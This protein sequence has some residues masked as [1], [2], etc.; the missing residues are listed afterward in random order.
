MTLSLNF[1]GI[2]NS[3]LILSLL[4]SSVA[5]CHGQ[6]LTPAKATTS[7]QTDAKPSDA[8]SDKATEDSKD[9]A[10]KDKKDK[11]EEEKLL[12]LSFRN[13]DMNKIGQFLSN[14]MKKP[15]VLADKV[16]SKKISII[17][18]QKKK[19][20]ELL[21]VLR[22]TL[23][24]NGV[25]IEELET[26][27]NLKPTEDMK[28]ANLPI[29]SAT[30]SLNDIEDQTLIV[31]K[32]FKVQYYDVQEIEKVIKPLLPDYVPIIVDPSTKSLIIS[33]MV[34]QL[35]RVEGVINTLDL[36]QVNKTE[37][38]IIKVENADAAWIV[39]VLK[40]LLNN[41]DAKALTSSNS[42][43]RSRNSYYGW[44]GRSNPTPQ[45][46]GNT[47]VVIPRSDGA[48]I[49]MPEIAKN[50]I[51]AV[52]P[53]ETMLQIIK[54]VD[55]L[56]APTDG[57]EAFQM[58][59]IKY[60]NVKTISEEI[61]LVISSMPDLSNSVNI[62]PSIPARKLFVTGSQKGHK[63]VEILLKELD[64][65]NAGNRQMQ[66]FKLEYA[67]SVVIAENIEK[68]FDNRE[69]ES[70]Y[71]NY[72]KSY[73]KSDSASTRIK[74]TS[75]KTQNAVI[76]QTDSVTMDKVTKKIQE[77]D[78]PIN[79]EDVK[80][81]IYTLKYA[82]PVKVEDI[83]VNLYSKKVKENSY[84]SWW[85][86]EPEE[87][88]TPAGRLFGEFSFQSLADTNQ[89]VVSAKNN[90]NFAII[91]EIIAELDQPQS[92]G[93]PKVVELKHANAE[94]LAEQLNAALSKSG[95]IASILRSSRGQLTSTGTSTASNSQNN[96]NNSKNNANSNSE[97]M[98]FW[99]EKGDDNEKERPASSMIGKL[100][101][102]PIVRRNALLIVAAPA[103]IDSICSMVE[104]LDVPGMQVI[105]HARIAEIQH[106]DVTTLGARIS[107]DPDAFKDSASADQSIRL[108]G[109]VGYEDVFGQLFTNNNGNKTSQGIFGANIN[110]NMLIQFLQRKYGLQILYEPKLYTADNQL[111]EFFDGQ[112]IAVQKNAQTTSD[113]G[114]TRTFD[115]KAIGTRL[116]V[117]PHIT[118]EG[119]VDLKVNL[120]LSRILPSQSFYGNPTFDR[121]ETNT[122]V[123][124]HSG[125]TV[126]LSGIIRTEDFIDERKLPLVSEIPLLGELFKSKDKSRKNRE[127]II[128]ITPIV[129]SNNHEETDDVMA[130]YKETL[131]AIERNLNGIPEPAP[132]PES[133][134]EFL[135]EH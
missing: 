83:L 96:N 112:D 102:V 116:K 47:P 58:Y 32:C 59:S 5:V 62:V 87:E 39:S 24:Q 35:L 109:N 37:K 49:L 134:P 12:A 29:V 55:R 25:F 65:E 57:E 119:E 85:N 63:I 76:V 9:K 27:I 120:E 75:D 26:H 2:L 123:V 31:R 43:S 18:N 90:K 54:W 113:G 104:E 79:P 14:E 94:E 128:F 114:T 111:A 98:R 69:L 7:A 126:M 45:M 84:R 86:D 80:P 118:K 99:W 36:P 93:M 13:A 20:K 121:R 68:L 92:V 64:V 48:V 50:W 74:V 6:G 10:K 108:G 52:A 107:S 21:P 73:R 71:G 125:Q 135:A 132:A 11:K 3:V 22:Q 105:I 66:T 117:R 133:E 23:Y 56:D 131:N 60:S 70:S 46:K 82:D 8:K 100:R 61:A 67:D 78:K 41:G 1:R 129:I 30:Q 77:W 115:Y 34:R 17:S 127:M 110:V 16:Q 89:L 106:D 97:M 95:T 122:H 42:S 4:T 51:V 44:R 88:I 28:H 15:V 81:R 40:M 101:I 124:V 19:F 91:D 72:Y 38:Q 33:D 130:P 53:A 103:Q